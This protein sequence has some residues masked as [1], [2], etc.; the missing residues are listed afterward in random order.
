MTESLAEEYPEAAPFIQKAVDR[1]GEEWVLENY[2][3]EI[4]PLGQVMRV[5]E[6]EELPFYD[7]DEHEAMTNE[8]KAEMYGAWA[9]YRENLKNGTKPGE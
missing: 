6:K 9:E 8:E 5:P 2:Y 7:P 1:H 4:Y 3:R